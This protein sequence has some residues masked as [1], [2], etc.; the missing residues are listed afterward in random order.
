MRHYLPDI[1]CVDDYKVMSTRFWR[2]IKS[3]PEF[4]KFN[5][6]HKNK[7]TRHIVHFKQDKL[8]ISFIRRNNIH[9]NYEI[10][11]DCGNVQDI[12]HVHYANLPI[13]YISAFVING[14]G[15]SEPSSVSTRKSEIIDFIDDYCSSY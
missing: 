4:N 7:V 6:N 1:L 9:N 11:I 3:F 14:F 15:D 8:T 10:H 13:E 5:E 12:F 2:I